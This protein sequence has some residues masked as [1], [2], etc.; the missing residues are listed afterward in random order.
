MRDFASDWSALALNAAA[1]GHMLD[2]HGAG[3][4]IGET[5]GACARRGFGGITFWSRKLRG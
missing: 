3:W 1:L 5:I 4:T 2:G